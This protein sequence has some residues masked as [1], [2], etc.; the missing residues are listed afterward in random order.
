MT[1]NFELGRDFCT[2]HLPLFHHRIFTRSEVIVLTNKQTNKQTQKQTDA[3]ENIQCSS[4][5]YNIG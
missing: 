5:R 2:M 4:L 1:S 3:A